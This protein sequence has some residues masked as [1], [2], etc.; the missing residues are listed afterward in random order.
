MVEA[1]PVAGL[2]V[3]VW[4]RGRSWIPP[5]PVA[6]PDGPIRTAA[7]G[8]FRTKAGLASGSSYR[9][10]V[11]S[12]GYEPILSAWTTAVER[13]QLPLDLV[14]RP[15]RTIAGRVVDRRGQPVAG[16]EVFQAGDGPEPASTRTDDAG[17]FAL[18]GSA[19]VRCSCSPGAAASGSTGRWSRM[20]SRRSR[21]C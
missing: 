19:T 13:P 12:P 18:A 15:L 1:R 16:V 8:S 5:T 7:D 14:L 10:V 2:T 4:S 17:R 6:F 20:R 3:E 9:L 11:R 21:S